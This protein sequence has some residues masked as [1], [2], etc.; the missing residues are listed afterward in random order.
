MSEFEALLSLLLAA[1]VLAALARK[2]G[3]PYPAYL[4]LGGAF[5]RGASGSAADV[6]SADQLAPPVIVCPFHR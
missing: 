5:A 1:V 2:V 3:A 4:A 6:P